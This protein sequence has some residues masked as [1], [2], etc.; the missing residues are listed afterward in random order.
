MRKSLDRPDEQL[1]VPGITADVVN[2]G[3]TTVSRVRYDPGAHCP[4]VGYE[5]KPECAAHHAGYVIEGRLRVEMT[6]GSTIEVGPNE[7]FDIPPGHD[8]WAIGDTPLLV[9]SWAGFRS[10]AP[11]RSGERVLLTLLFTD[12]VGST[13]RARELGDAAWKEQLSHHNQAV[14]SIL[15]RNRGREVATT[16][17]G[18][19]AAF[20]GAGRALRAANEIIAQALAD[21]LSIRA[22]AHSGEVELVGDDVRGIT[23]HEAARIAAAAGENEILVSEITR[24]L[25]AGTG[26]EFES[27]GAHELRGLDE[28]RQLFAVLTSDDPT[29]TKAS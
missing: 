11:D 8:G 17:D 15:D 27:R 18:F 25:S 1:N 4:Q 22:G 5:G 7:A 24:L 10:W 13:S 29:G 28:P 20:D 3:D 26:F 9:I 6:D 2:I 16:G 21:G 14:R 19:L 23:V 12:I